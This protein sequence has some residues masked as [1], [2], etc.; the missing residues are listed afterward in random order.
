MNRRKPNLLVRFLRPAHAWLYQLSGGRLG[1]KL[2]DMPVL[3]LSS[4]GRKTG[5][6]RIRAL[7]YLFDNG[8]YVLAASNGGADYHPDWWLNLEAN[9]KAAIQVGSKRLEVTAQEV[10]G[11]ERAKLWQRFVKMEERYANYERRTKRH[12]PVV[13]LKTEEKQEHN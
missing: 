4:V 12:I 2:L 13:I 7:S 8:N 5:K 9:P 11:E 6:Q 10:E 3:V 1:T